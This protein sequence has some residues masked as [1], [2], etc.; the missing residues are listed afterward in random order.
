M[1]LAEELAKSKKR[2]IM[3]LLHR[4]A[5]PSREKQ[6]L[7][8]S[9]TPAMPVAR[10]HEFC[11]HERDR[12]WWALHGCPFADC[13]YVCKQDRAFKEHL[14]GHSAWQHLPPALQLKLMTG[15]EWELAAEHQ[16][17][18]RTYNKWLE[19]YPNI[20]NAKEQQELA[21]SGRKRSSTT[22]DQ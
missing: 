6:P 4:L 21:K 20:L 12:A 16:G 1:P 18:L 22:R 11:A 13:K 2:P 7:F 3:E 15:V 10:C 19:E 14:E 17:L 8:V 5:H 9:P